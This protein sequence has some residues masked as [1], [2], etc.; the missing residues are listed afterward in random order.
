M[1][2][3]GGKVNKNTWVIRFEKRKKII[4]HLSVC[5]YQHQYKKPTAKKNSRKFLL[6]AFGFRVKVLELQS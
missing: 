2:K 1:L 4:L 5:A 3:N 6:M